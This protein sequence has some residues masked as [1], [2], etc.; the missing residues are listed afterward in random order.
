MLC[1]GLWSC[2]VKEQ[3]PSQY[4]EAANQHEV[5]RRAAFQIPKAWEKETAAED[6]WEYAERSKKGDIKNELIITFSPKAELSRKAAESWRSL[7]KFSEQNDNIKNMKQSNSSIANSPAVEMEYTE[8]GKNGEAISKLILLQTDTG[9]I[10]ISFYSLSEAGQKDFDKV[11][12]SI[13]VE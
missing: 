6:Y 11:I 2:D 9:L 1:L 8:A 3:E 12:E 4:N 7:E 10:S 5:F 13:T